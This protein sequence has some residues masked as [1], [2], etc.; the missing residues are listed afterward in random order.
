MLVGVPAVEDRRD[1]ALVVVVV[2][3]LVVVVVVVV[4]LPS[5]ATYAGP[6]SNANHHAGDCPS[7]RTSDTTDR[8]TALRQCKATPWCVWRP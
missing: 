4:V 8:S 3:D 1:R 7:D 6:C 2:V 5:Y